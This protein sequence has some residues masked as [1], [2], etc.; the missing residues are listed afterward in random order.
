MQGFQQMNRNG[1]K[2][3]C[4][5]PEG[6]LERNCLMTLWTASLGAIKDSRMYFIHDE[7]EGSRNDDQTSPTFSHCLA[8]EPFSQA[9][10]PLQQSFLLFGDQPATPVGLPKYWP[11]QSPKIEPL[12]SPCLRHPT[13]LIGKLGLQTLLNTSFSWARSMLIPFT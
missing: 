3:T 4:V 12:V 10:A 8:S 2:E 13:K 1:M 9:H 7:E 11:R 6:K 5:R